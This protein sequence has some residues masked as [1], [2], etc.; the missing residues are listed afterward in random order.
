MGAIAASRA[1]HPARTHQKSTVGWTVLDGPIAVKTTACIPAKT[2]GH[3]PA[4]T[5]IGVPWT[6]LVRSVTVGAVFK[7]II[8]STASIQPV[9]ARARKQALS[10]GATHAACVA[11][12][13]AT[14][15]G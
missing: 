11:A 6:P 1:C 13:A 8:E 14:R 2:D 9:S 10:S 5:N 12:A 3:A 4:I 15:S 7:A